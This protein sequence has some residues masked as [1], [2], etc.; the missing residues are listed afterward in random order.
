MRIAGYVRVST[1][2]QVKTEV[3]SLDT[4]RRAIEDW[5]RMTHPK[6]FV[7]LYADVDTGRTA[8]RDALQMLL[9]DVEEGR[10]DCVVVYMLDRWMRN[11]EEALRTL[12]ILEA[13]NVAFVSLSERIDTSSVAGAFLRDMLLRVAQLFSEIHAQRIRDKVRS[14]AKAGRWI[15]GIPPFGYYVKDKRLHPHPEFAP[16]VRRAFEIF[17]N[18]QSLGEV[19]RFLNREVGDRRDTWR[20]VPKFYNNSVKSMLRSPTY[21][22]RIVIHGEVLCERAH[23]PIV[24]EEL[25]REVQTLLDHPRRV[26]SYNSAHRNYPL[27]GIASCYYCGRLMSPY[28]VRNQHGRYFYYRCSSRLRGLQCLGG[29]VPAE[30]IEDAVIGGV[31][32]VGRDPVLLAAVVGLLSEQNGLAELER[33]IEEEEKTIQRL[34]QAIERGGEID[35]LVERLQYHRWNLSRLQAQR[36]MYKIEGASVSVAE[37]Q[38]IMSELPIL[39]QLASPEERKSMLLAVVE[40]VVV[41]TVRRQAVVYIRSVRRGEQGGSP[42]IITF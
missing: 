21:L 28:W 24:D 30:A 33:Q 10:I 32:E 2:D 22:G 13:Q 23:V 19:R 16:L 26:Y 42:R 20:K 11:L 12:R 29:N 8:Q 5:V 15:T 27:Q 41:D 14:E 1:S 38:R 35:V 34:V 37:L 18:T 39:W 4:Q 31:A 40:R 3:N 6:S 25:W 36:E 17:R 9:E 7:C